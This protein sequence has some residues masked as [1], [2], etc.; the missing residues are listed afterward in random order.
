MYISKLLNMVC[1][2]IFR[3]W[4]WKCLFYVVFRG[5]WGL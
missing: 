4:S 1:H 2:Y 5:F 3:H